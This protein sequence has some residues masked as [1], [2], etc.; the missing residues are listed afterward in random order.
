M[1]Q[2]LS[3]A[4]AA[5]AAAA[6]VVAAVA[7]AAAGDPRHAFTSAGRATAKAGVLPRTALPA[8]KWK[9]AA[10]DFTQA[11]P[12]CFVQGYSLAALTLTGEAGTTYSL[13]GGV[14]SIES[15]VYVFSSATQAKRAVTILSPAGLGECEGSALITTFA[16]SAKGRS[17]KVAS[18]QSLKVASAAFATRTVVQ[19]HTAQGDLIVDLVD[20][21]I[22]N[23]NV[24]AGLHFLRFNTLWSTATL[25]ALTAKA[26]ALIARA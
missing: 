22:R 13:A 19:L 21:G 2:R 1:R 26:A 9:A 6:L 17:G 11:N 10:T 25:D 5:A 20:V 4:A 14:P 18:A 3:T 15:D 24:L 12:A 16:A 8:G 23:G 7:T